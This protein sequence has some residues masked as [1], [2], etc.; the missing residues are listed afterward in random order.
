M[1]DIIMGGNMKGTPND[2]QPPKRAPRRPGAVAQRKRE[3]LQRFD[4]IRR[5]RE[6]EIRRKRE[7]LLRLVKEADARVKRQATNTRLANDRRLKF[8]LGGLALAQLRAGGLGGLQLTAAHLAGL[9]DK[10]RHLLE[11]VL[12]GQ[13][14]AGAANSTGARSGP[15]SGSQIDVIL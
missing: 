4:E 8:A 6:E 3:E 11:A 15:A 1:H 2:Q 5:R 14:D 12:A 13:E 7:E 9:P 10:D